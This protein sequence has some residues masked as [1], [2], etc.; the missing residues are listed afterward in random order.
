M[1]VGIWFCVGLDEV[2][3]WVKDGL[4]V[5]TEE[6]ESLGVGVLKL[7]DLGVGMRPKANSRM[8]SS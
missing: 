8:A 4:G 5:G 3:F 7:V 2:G 6:K 1:G